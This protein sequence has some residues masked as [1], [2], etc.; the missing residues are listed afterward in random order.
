MNVANYSFELVDVGEKALTPA[1]G[2]AIDGLRPARR[3]LFLN[4]DDAQVGECVNV[5]IQIAVGEIARSDH[6]LQTAEALY[7]RALQCDPSSGEAHLRLGII[8]ADE[9]HYNEAIGQLKDAIRL[10]PKES[11]AHYHLAEVYSHTGRPAEAKAEYEKVRQI[12]AGK[13]NGVDVT[14]PPKP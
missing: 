10:Q 11:S 12:Q 6:D 1:F 7:Q 4:R 9:K 13:D 14:V 5:A 8:L 2:D 3:A